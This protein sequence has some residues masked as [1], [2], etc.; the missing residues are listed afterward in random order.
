MKFESGPEKDE[1]DI[2]KEV[3]SFLNREHAGFESSSTFEKI[4]VIGRCESCGLY[5]V[6]EK[7]GG[8]TWVMP[9][10]ELDQEAASKKLEGRD[11]CPYCM[12]G[13][14]PF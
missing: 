6:K 14:D 4:G 3:A 5:K 9:T 13:E 12:S 11:R 10:P 2:D 8:E 1:E 7:G